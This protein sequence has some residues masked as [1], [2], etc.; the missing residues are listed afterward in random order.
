MLP[1]AC[2]WRAL[3]PSSF[4]IIGIKLYVVYSSLVH[5]ALYWIKYIYWIKAVQAACWSTGLL[6][7]QMASLSA[8]PLALV[9]TT[10]AS[11]P[12]TIVTVLQG[13]LKTSTVDQSVPQPHPRSLK[14]L[15]IP[16]C[17]T[18]DRVTP[19]SFTHPGRLQHSPRTIFETLKLI[20]VFR[21][22][23]MP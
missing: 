12:E 23:F 8:H 14:Q 13:L 3:L 17:H 20:D 10:S 18:P 21:I 1:P 7:I 19:M 22:M 9:W 4:S 2:H 15:N 11:S 16:S 6:S 5:T